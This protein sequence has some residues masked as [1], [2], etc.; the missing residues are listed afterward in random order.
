MAL[1]EIVDEESI[2]DREFAFLLLNIGPIRMY[3]LMDT[4]NVEQTKDV[5]MYTCRIYSSRYLDT[6][7]HKIEENNI[8]KMLA[9]MHL[10]QRI[11]ECENCS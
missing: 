5:R 9:Y 3:I 8:G 4:R 10:Q 6:L 11:E 2:D 7:L 1:V